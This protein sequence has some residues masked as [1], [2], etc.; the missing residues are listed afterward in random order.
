[1][2][3]S[4]SSRT[5]HGLLFLHTT[6]ILLFVLAVL[7]FIVGF[8]TFKNLTN[9]DYHGTKIIYT[10]ADFRNTPTKHSDDLEILKEWNN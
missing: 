1:M 9:K 8:S 3:N 7:L 5:T 10:S 6:M 4:S 2:A